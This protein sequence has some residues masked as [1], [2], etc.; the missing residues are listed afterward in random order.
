[1]HHW[2]LEQHTPLH[3]RG[4]YSEFYDGMGEPELPASDPDP[5]LW[6][7]GGSASTVDERLRAYFSALKH[8]GSES[9]D[10][11]P[12]D[13]DDFGLIDGG[14]PIDPID[15]DD[16]DPIDGGD[17]TDP[18][19]ADDRDPID[20][21]TID[22]VLGGDRDLLPCGDALGGDESSPFDI[23]IASD[24]FPLDDDPSPFDIAIAAADAESIVADIMADCALN[25]SPIM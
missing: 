12:I 16:F 11:D 8:G 10:F 21:P 18:I 9:D 24:D 2:R 7:G 22:D 14:D 6:V 4:G 5:V 25:T 17:P 13:T 3:R 23:A 19:D 20:D 15:T 1:M